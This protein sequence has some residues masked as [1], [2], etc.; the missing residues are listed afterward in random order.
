MAL[1]AKF[2]FVQSIEQSSTS[3]IDIHPLPI[4]FAKI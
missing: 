3:D 1:Q 4:S 2:R